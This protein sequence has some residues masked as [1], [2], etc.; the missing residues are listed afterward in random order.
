[1]INTNK[2]LVWV[3]GIGGGKAISVISEEAEKNMPDLTAYYF[4]EL[5][6]L[7]AGPAAVAVAWKLSKN[8]RHERKAD[9]IGL[10]GV[11]MFIDRTAKLAQEQ[12]APGRVVRR[13]YRTGAPPPGSRRTTGHWPYS[14]QQRLPFQ[15]DITW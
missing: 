10:A 2:V 6:G 11:E 12:L 3:G 14:S 4:K 7:L 15:S 1:M 5:V 13:T 8:P 9:L